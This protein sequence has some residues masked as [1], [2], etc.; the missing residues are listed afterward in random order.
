[1]DPETPNVLIIGAGGVGVIVALSLHTAGK[2]N[3]SLVVRSDYKHVLERGY[4]ISSVDHGELD[5]WRPHRLYRTVDAIAEGNEERVFFDY[6]VITTKNIPDGPTDS[7]VPS[8][9]RPVLESNRTIDAKRQTNIVL[10][11]NGID[12]E[13]EVFQTLDKAFYNYTLLSGVILIGSHKVSHG[14]I[15]HVTH[16]RL[17]VGA[18]ESGDAAATAAARG[19]IALYNNERSSVEFDLRVRYSRWK[20]LLY[21]AAIGA[22]TTLVDLDVPRSLQFGVNGK[23]T[24][25]ELFRPAM[26]EIIAIAA[27]EGIVI[28]EKVID[29]FIDASRDLIYKPSMC[30]DAE[31]DQLME[32][33]VILGNPVR[34]AKAH[35]VETPILSTL[36]NLLLL[37]QGRIKEKRGLIHFDEKNIRVV[38]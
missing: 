23:S 2:C 12:I 10:I 38:E 19:F 13:K 5:G 21:N 4:K 31:Q 33:E 16:E 24:E 8:L 30:L 17:S 18:F 36:Y 6:V 34:I 26:K 25:N 27:T 37:I 3:V 7:R 35:R 32:L 11:Q 15:E 9:I 29:F 14:V 22:I 20:K 28:D 1:M